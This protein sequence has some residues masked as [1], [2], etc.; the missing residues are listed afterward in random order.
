MSVG[1]DPMSGMTTAQ[2]ATINRGQVVLGLLLSVPLVAF[3]HTDSLTQ[4]DN[5]LAKIVLWAGLA[6][7][8][9]HALRGLWRQNNGNLIADASHVARRK[10]AALMVGFPI[11][12]VVWA[13]AIGFTFAVFMFGVYTALMCAAAAVNGPYRIP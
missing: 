11:L 6:I 10:W 4:S 3:L 5:A 13:V 2:A 9:T 7:M 8:L 1:G 12:A